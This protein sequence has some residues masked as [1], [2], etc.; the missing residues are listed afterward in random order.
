MRR[1]S[2]YRREG[3]EVEPNS[4]S[5]PNTQETHERWIW[6]ISNSLSSMKQLYVLLA[7]S[8]KMVTDDVLPLLKFVI[9]S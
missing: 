4:A 9:L 1:E 6:H 3:D 5:L 8:S 7:R 2:Q